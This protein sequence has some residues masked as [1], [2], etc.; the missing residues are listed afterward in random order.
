M[1]LLG[2]SSLGQTQEDIF[3]E[4]QGYRVFYS[5]FN[6][7]FLTPEVAAANGLVRAN[8]RAYLNIVVTQVTPEGQS[9]GLPASLKGSAANLMQQAQPLEFKEIREPTAVY[10]LAPIRHTNEE[11]Y[12][13]SVVVTPEGSE[14]AIEIKFSKKLYVE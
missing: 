9:L 2:F 14:A 13:F 6:S 11:V 10:Y 1:L 3:V 4:E 12:N 5:V 8:D 7:A